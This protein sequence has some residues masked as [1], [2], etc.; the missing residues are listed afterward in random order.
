MRRPVCL[1]LALFLTAGLAAASD[2]KTYKTRYDAALL[3]LQ[4][5]FAEEKQVL[6]RRYTEALQAL[7]ERVRK[8]GELDK[9]I[10]VMAELKRFEQE[11]SV[12]AEPAALEDLQRL[13]TSYAR[14]FSA[15]SVQRSTS[16]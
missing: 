9:T 13:Q 1:I 10:S 11:R 3:A 7:Q 4:Q 8:A 14:H 2:L 16:L 5:E 15:M 12:A 6:D